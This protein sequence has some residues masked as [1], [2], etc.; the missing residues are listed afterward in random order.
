MIKKICISALKAGDIHTFETLYTAYYKELYRFAYYYIMCEEAEDI[1]QNVFVKLYE[2]HSTIRSDADLKS[3]LYS[4][5]KH[6]CLNF[7][8]HKKIIDNSQSKIAEV[9][10]QYSESNDTDEKISM[11][12]SYIQKLTPQQQIIIRL[13]AEGNDYKQIGAILNISPVTVHTHIVRIYK[14]FR[15]N[16]FFLYTIF[17]LRVY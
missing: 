8:R 11:I 16:I 5:V 10:M 2:N 12:N 17:I 6:G 1:V 9:I 4:S 13:K 15:K 14:F 7:L 3:Y